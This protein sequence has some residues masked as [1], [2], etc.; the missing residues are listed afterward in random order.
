LASVFTG[1]CTGRSRSQYL[2]KRHLT[3]GRAE[4]SEYPRLRFVKWLIVV[5]YGPLNDAHDLPSLGLNLFRRPNVRDRR[6]KPELIRV[7]TERPTAD[8]PNSRSSSRRDDRLR[9]RDEAFQDLAADRLEIGL[10]LGRLTSGIGY[11]E[12]LFEPLR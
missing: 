10:A 3:A 1:R 2:G 4:D 9:G 5:G 6:I 12:Y 7:R 11:L 8:A